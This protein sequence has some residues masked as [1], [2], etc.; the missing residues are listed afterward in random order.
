[1]AH[2]DGHADHHI[3]P[4]KTLA[5]VFGALV[6][7]TVLT[8]AVAQ[9]DLGPLEIPVALGIAIAKSAL[10]VMFFMALKYDKPVNSMVFTV[11]TVFVVVFLVFTLFD[12]AFRGDI[13]NV[14]VQTI[15]EEEAELER[16]RERE[17]D[18]EQ[19]RVTPSDYGQDGTGTGSEDMNDQ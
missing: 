18:P 8:V 16:L 7:L 2:S 12:T 9:V 15:E 6:V 14:G 11:G 13:G 4:F 3:I 1:M 17:P 10:V 19:L 5:N